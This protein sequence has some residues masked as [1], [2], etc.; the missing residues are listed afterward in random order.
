MLINAGC[1]PEQSAALLFF[2]PA[3]GARGT[4]SKDLVFRAQLRDC[5]GK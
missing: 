2:A 5:R 3:S 1:H 4:E